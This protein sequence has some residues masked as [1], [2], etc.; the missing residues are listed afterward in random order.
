MP[1]FRNQKKLE[2]EKM[3]LLEEIKKASE[4]LYYISETDAEIRPFDGGKSE[5]VTG[6]EILERTESEPGAMIEERDFD[7]FFRRLVKTEDWYDE[8]DL[9]NVRRFICLKKL[10]EENLHDLRVFRIG[11]IQIKIYVVGIDAESNLSGIQTEAVET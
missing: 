1:F 4:G 3:N 11:E 8:E 5:T 10:L 9:V 6:A 7:E 2:S